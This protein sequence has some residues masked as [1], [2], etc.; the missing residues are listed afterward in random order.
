MGKVDRISGFFWLIFSVFG[1][2]HSYKLGLGSLHQPGPGFLFFWTGIIVALLSA[3]LIV[4]TFRRQPSGEA[5]GSFP[6][7]WKVN[8]IAFI[9]ISLFLYAVLME[10]LGFLI[11]TLLLF[12]FLLGIIEKK[13]WRFSVLVSLAVTT[14]SYLVFEV[15]LHSQLP[16]GLLEFLRF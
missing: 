15:A 5:E 10:R 4:R 2:Y 9:L 12:F 6:G 16:K 8:K 14:L 13:R 7:K 1:S 3:S 11:V